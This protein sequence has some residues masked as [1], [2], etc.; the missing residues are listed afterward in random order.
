MGRKR[1]RRRA[2]GG[3]EETRPQRFE[4]KVEGGHSRL[5]GLELYTCLGRATIAGT[6]TLLDKF[7]AA[8]NVLVLRHGEVRRCGK[9]EWGGLKRRGGYALDLYLRRAG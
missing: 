2:E 5:V 1:V 8:W 4:G 3:S 7:V 9:E 6:F